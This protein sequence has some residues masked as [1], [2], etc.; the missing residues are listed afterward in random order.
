VPGWVSH[1][2][3]A[4]EEPSL[5]R[6]FA[7]LASFSRLILFDK[8]GTGLSDRVREDQLPTL[9]TRMDDLRS[10]CDAVGS[11]RAALLGVSEGAPLCV[12]FAAT[13]PERTTAL[14]LFGGY[15]RRLEAPDYPWGVSPDAQAT[16]L[17][18]IAR[19]WGGPVGL[20]ARAPSRMNDARFRETWARYL[21]SGASPAAVLALTRMN[22]EID[23]RSVLPNVHVP[24]L[25]LHRTGDRAID[26]EAGRHLAEQIPGASFIELG[27]EDHLPWVG[28]VDAVLEQIEQFLTGAPPRPHVDRVLTTI[29][30]TDIVGSTQ[31]LSD[32]GDAV[33]KE[34]LSAH[35]ERS[36]AQ[37]EHH[38]GTYIHT[39][40][41]G[42]LATFDGPARAVRAALA[43]GAAV[44]PLGLDIRAGCHTGEVEIGDGGVAGIAVHIGARVA[45]LAGPGEVLVS[46]TV[47]DLVAGAGLEFEERGEHELKGVPGSW[48]LFAV[49]PGGSQLGEFGR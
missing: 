1:L 23:V 28:D 42:L 8:R 30:F 44:R 10:V 41:D 6:F 16:F 29:L 14:I 38:H 22:A 7:R 35:D 31:K 40:G 17:D 19:D 11:E 46:G 15:A 45:A 24:A 25:V 47:K 36:R 39:T 26:V 34:T 32:L 13:Y 48:R 27:G 18:E 33:W 2:E 49:I 4:W 37:I 9:E 20:E 3:A 21:R 5:A 43:I 12:L